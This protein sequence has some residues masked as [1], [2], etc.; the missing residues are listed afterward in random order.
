[1][2][3]RYLILVIVLLLNSCGF[4]LRGA[5][6]FDISFVY[7]KSESANTIATEIGR[8]LT[9]QGV[10]IV[11]N[12]NAAQAIVYLQNE[13]VDRRVLTVSSISG[14]Q[15][16]FEL[17]YQVTMEVRKPDDTVLL[18]KQHITLLR[19]YMF[20]EKAVLA[21]WSEDE[22]LR[23]EMFRDVVAQIMRR[24]Q[25]VKL[26]KI[27][28]T[29][30]EFKNLKPKYI[31]GELLNLD[32]IEKNTRTFPVDIWLTVTIGDDIW[33]INS[34][35]SK[36]LHEKSQPWKRNVTATETTHQLLE[37]N[38]QPNV[39]GEYIFRAI[40]TAVDAGL[41]LNNLAST[42]RSYLVE[43]KTIFTTEEP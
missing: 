27:E 8:L 31:A 9:E 24:L 23:K 12:P 17:N 35:D 43:S 20:D 1:M 10:K 2:N 11:S 5:A 3:K 7:I 28:L 4:H 32:L 16:E 25:V 15:E 13:T 29:Q 36:L 40:Y 33:F 42:K 41:N 14:K 21:M 34:K 30:L 38:V 26:G 37:F 22:M 39:D 19:D 6:G 18:E